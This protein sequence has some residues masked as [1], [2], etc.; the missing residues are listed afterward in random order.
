[1]RVNVLF[2]LV[3]MVIGSSAVRA[4]YGSVVPYIKQA[5][6]YATTNPG[7]GATAKL[8]A[9]KPIDFMS[10]VPPTFRCKPGTVV[11]LRVHAFDGD[12]QPY[13]EQIER[14]LLSELAVQGLLHGFT[15]TS[16]K[17]NEVAPEGSTI[18]DVWVDLGTGEVFQSFETGGTNSRSDS[19][20]T[21][22]GSWRTSCYLSTVDRSSSTTAE[23]EVALDIMAFRKQGQDEIP[24]PMP[25]QPRSDV[26]RV[27]TNSVE[28]HGSSDS[29]YS[30]SS[31]WGNS[32]RTASSYCRSETR[33][34]GNIQQKRM[35][36]AAIAN[37]TN[38][39]APL[40]VRGLAELAVFEEYQRVK[41]TGSEAPAQ[42]EPQKTIKMT[43]EPCK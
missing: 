9:P 10:I 20:R 29:N 4:E 19:G 34:T 38:G 1:M 37:S 18:L 39:I 13:I 35:V 25:I 7:A 5:N 24:L 30:D 21:R 41:M 31:R 40:F 23:L 27:Q 36:R 6:L 14:A 17:M 3:A 26:Q 2:V 8:E 22:R 42:P 28:D 11:R 16:L 32:D 33:R 15:V 12:S 43:E